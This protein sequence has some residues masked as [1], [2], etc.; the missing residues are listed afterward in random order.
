MWLHNCVCVCLCVFAHACVWVCV[1]DRRQRVTCVTEVNRGG[2]VLTAGDRFQGSEVT[3]GVNR[4]LPKEQLSVHIKTHPAPHLTLIQL[5]L[6]SSSAVFSV[7]MCQPQTDWTVLASIGCGCITTGSYL[8]YAAECAAYVF[9][10][11]SWENRRRQWCVFF[12]LFERKPE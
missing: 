6:G 3:I 8:Q 7:F 9:S 10:S 1:L 12:S 11:K 4:C 5:F 2:S